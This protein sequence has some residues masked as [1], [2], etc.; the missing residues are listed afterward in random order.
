[1]EQRVSERVVSERVVSRKVVRKTNPIIEKFKAVKS[2][3]G[4][5]CVGFL[6]VPLAI[7][8]LFWGEKLKKSSIVVESLSLEQAS[9]VTAESGLHKIT[10]E[11]EVTSATEAPELGKVLYYSYS[12]EEFREEEETEYDTVTNIEDGVEIEET[13]ERIKLV[14]KW[15]SIDSSSDWAEF[16]LGKYTVDTTGAELKLDLQ[17]KTYYED[18][19]GYVERISSSPYLGQQRI[20]VS[21]LSVD[22]EL[23]IIGELTSDK[24][25]KGEVFII[26]TKSDEQ[27]LADIKAGETVA[28]WGLKFASWLLFTMGFLTILGPILSILDFIPVA[29]KAANCLASVISAVVAIGLVVAGTIII[30][31]WWLCLGLFV[32]GAVAAVIL[33]VTLLTRKKEKKGEG[34][35]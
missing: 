15:V 24:I 4:G 7:G 27:L 12:K 14:E 22:T 11:V 25:K 17:S 31:F 28:Y 32:V 2:S 9:E 33:L 6:L 30:K 8:A 1:M 23:L 29:G 20:T 21:Y 35:K 13:V 16:K 19:S 10:G 5:V 26:T 34:G 3:F 18:I